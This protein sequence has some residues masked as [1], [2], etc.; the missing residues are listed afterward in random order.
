MEAKEKELNYIIEEAKDETDE[1][2]ELIRKMEQIKE[3]YQLVNEAR[4]SLNAL[5]GGP[6]AETFKLKGSIKKSP[7]QPSLRFWKLC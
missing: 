7:N 2:E 3:S 5:E 4:I 6:C 1:E